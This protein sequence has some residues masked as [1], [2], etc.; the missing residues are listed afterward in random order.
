MID[1]TAACNVPGRELHFPKRAGNRNC[2]NKL[3]QTTEA[4]LNP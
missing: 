4:G 2:E 1:K 3:K